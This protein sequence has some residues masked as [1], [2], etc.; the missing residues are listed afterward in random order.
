MA[1]NSA[2]PD[3]LDNLADS[4]FAEL[5]PELRAPAQQKWPAVRRVL[6]R[7]KDDARVRPVAQSAARVLAGSDFAAQTIERHPVMFE[8]LLAS[9]DLARAYE[10]GEI[11]ERVTT[12]SGAAGDEAELKRAL[13][14]IRRRE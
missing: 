4:A 6:A 11:A 14:V 5:P 3:S 9:G 1:F 2:T 7:F 13:R 12:A 10:P 8:D